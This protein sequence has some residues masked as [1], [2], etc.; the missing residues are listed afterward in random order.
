MFN[1]GVTR[2]SLAATFLVLSTLAVQAQSATAADSA[3]NAGRKQVTEYLD[4]IAAEQTAA[5]RTAVAAIATRTQ[6]EARQAAV[7]KKILALIGGLP[8]KTPLHAKLVGVT[9]AQGFRIEKVIYDSQ[10]GFPVTALLYLPDAKPGAKAEKLPA[11]VVAPGH[12]PTGKA[13]DFGFAS[14]FARNGFAVL[15]YDPIGQGERLQ[16][17]DPAKPGTS[18]ATRPTG[19]HGEAGLQPTL[20]GDAVARYF[21]W[22]GMRAVDYLESRSEIDANRIGA[23]GCSGGGAMTALLGAL[24][25]RIK[26]T[27]TAC[28]I[29]SFDTLLPAIGAQDAEQSTPNFIASGL[30]FPDWVELAAPRPYAIIATTE[31]MFPFAGVQKTEAEAR[32]FY[33]FFGADADLEFLTGP[34][35]HGNLGPIQARIVSFFLKHL[36]PGADAAHPVLPPPGAPGV[37]PF[38]LPPGITKDAFQDTPTGQVATSYPHVEAVHRL[39][40]KRYESMPPPKALSGEALRAAI[41][42]VTKSAARPAAHGS[43]TSGLVEEGDLTVSAAKGDVYS[44]R[45]TLHSEPGI[46]LQGVITAH[47]GAGV[48]PAV[49]LLTNA[50]SMPADSSAQRELEGAMERMAEA[51]NVV[52]ALTPRPSPP[53]TEETKSPILGPF[54]LT[55]LRAELTGKTIMGMRI[56]DTIRAV[57]YLASRSDVDAKRISALASGHYGLVLLHAAVLDSRLAHISVDHALS[58]YKSLIEAPMPVGAP[59]DILPGVVRHYDLPELQHAMKSRLTL[60]HPLNGT[61]D[62]SIS[63][64]Q[65]GSR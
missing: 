20:I 32:R 48:H 44:K 62:L 24:D 58:S 63:T 5:R 26:A 30:D 34:G 18:L 59:E 28:Y 43:K 25:T 61:D 19:E 49:L 15:S 7:R 6:A 52:L 37:S 17:P 23:F 64:L 42:E 12:G 1:A 39:N 51:G 46:D 38:A 35:H 9:Q 65:A 29:T 14:T 53:G 54:Y 50:A 13:S 4:H 27:G 40:L 41:R 11:I 2:T 60:T 21:A 31:D 10:P 33:G 8:E 22:D 56:D 45:V 57:D 16:Y 3:A 47:H 55:E 36:Q